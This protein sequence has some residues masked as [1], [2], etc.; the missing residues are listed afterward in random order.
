MKITK[1][2]TAYAPV[3]V[4]NTLWSVGVLVD[5][6]EISSPIK[7]HSRNNIGI[8]ILIILLF[9]TGGIILYRVQRKKAVLEERATHLETIAESLDALQES[10]KK[11]KDLTNMLP[12]IVFQTDINGNFEYV[13]Q[14]GFDTFGYSLD[15]IN[16][17]HVLNPF[18]IFLKPDQQKV[19][20]NTALILN[21]KNHKVG[22]VGWSE[23]TATRK[24][25]TQFPVSILTSHIEKD[26]K[27]IGMRGVIVD[28]TE[29]E[30]IE[31][32]KKQREV[33]E[34][35]KQSISEWINYIAHE[36]RGPIGHILSFST[37]GIEKSRK[38]D[39]NKQLRYFSQINKTGKNMHRILNDLLDLSKMEIG[40]MNFEM[41][42]TSINNILEGVLD[43]AKATI[44]EKGII[45]DIEETVIN[46]VVICDGFR[47]AQVIRNLLSNALKF[48]PKGKRI[49][50][51]YEETKIRRGRRDYDFETPALKTSIIDQGRGIPGDQLSS[52]FV[53]Y[54][55]SRLTKSTEGTGLGLPISKEIIEA[56]Y[57]QIEVTSEEGKGAAFHVILPY[58][59]ER[60]K[61]RN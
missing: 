12:V 30:K 19:A 57:G 42:K 38:S 43:E 27:I 11:F 6:S 44:E 58:E 8:A 25:S 36:L 20:M 28:L 47:I 31:E 34:R 29:K 54:S 50:I 16:N 35:A 10:E 15:D 59:Q 37:F 61:N 5:Y 56:H 23:Y 13:N 1:K 22:D 24:D 51:T 60:M 49:S 33:A 39:L 9:G 3:H 17:N 45:L 18:Q 14:A 26:G 40:K 32:L 52:I 55:Q 2:L 53:K 41:Q 48:T 21:R 46:T 7:T 4:G